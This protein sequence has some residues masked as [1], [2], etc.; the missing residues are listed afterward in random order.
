MVSV[1]TPAETAEFTKQE[2]KQRQYTALDGGM[3]VVVVPVS[4]EAGR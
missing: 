3:R 4:N 2:K 1:M